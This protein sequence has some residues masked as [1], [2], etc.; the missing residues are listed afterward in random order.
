MTFKIQ[1]CLQTLVT[2][3]SGITQG[4]K[5]FVKIR[6]SLIIKTEMF[7]KNVYGYNLILLCVFQDMTHFAEVR[8][9]NK[10]L[11]FLTEENFGENFRVLF[12]TVT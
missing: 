9:R 7:K 4:Q 2:P 5:I 6:F 11:L 10:H 8:P 3:I 12:P 1:I